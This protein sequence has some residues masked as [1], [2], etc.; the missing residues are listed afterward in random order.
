M[1]LDLTEIKSKAFAVYV[2]NKDEFLQLRDYTT[3]NITSNLKNS[4]AWKSGGVYDTYTKNNPTYE[5]CMAYA[6][7][8][9]SDKLIFKGF[10]DITWFENQ[11]HI[12]IYI[13]SDLLI[14]EELKQIEPT[15][16]FK[17]TITMKEVYNEH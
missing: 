5:F 9:T 15:L 10:G 8:A 6:Q 3:E 1:N 2:K 17:K 16:P 11:E 7:Q 13:F 4:E 12:P 14:E